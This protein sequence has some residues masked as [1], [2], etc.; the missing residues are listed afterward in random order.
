LTGFF[1][2][3][4][5]LARKKA[6]SLPS[7]RERS[8]TP[9]ALGRC[10]WESQ[11]VNPLPRTVLSASIC[12][13]GYRHSDSRPVRQESICVRSGPNVRHME[14]QEMEMEMETETEM[15]MEMEN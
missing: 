5:T 4:N 3:F 15:K 7:L 8:E 14:K 11:E 9:G 12:N 13:T 6:Y 1:I 2:P 10:N